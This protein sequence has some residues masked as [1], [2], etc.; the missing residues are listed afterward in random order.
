MIVPLN[1]VL[2]RLIGQQKEDDYDDRIF[3]VPLYD[4]CNHYL[5][6]WVKLAGIKKKTWHCDRHSFAVN[7]LNKGANIKVV[8]SLLGHTSLKI[9][10]RYLHVVDNLKHDA[11]DSL[12]EINYCPS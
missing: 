1:D 10:E 7:I 5:G 4:T 12:G 2:I 11:I 6:R 8:S 3:K 9:T